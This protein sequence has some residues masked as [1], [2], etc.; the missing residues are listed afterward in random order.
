MVNIGGIELKGRFTLAPMAGVSDFAFRLICAELGAAM[1][2]TEMISAKAL[3]YRDE[4]TASLLYNPP[5]PCPLAVQIFGHEPEVMAEAA[6]MA[7]EGSGADI[8]DINMGCPVGKIVKSG[9]GSALMRDPE[10]AGRIIEAVCAA[11][12]Q[13]VTVKFRKGWDGGSVNAVAFA[14]VCEQAGASA[15]AVHGRTRVQMYAGKADWDIIR[16]V[17]KAVHIPVTANGD[18]FSGAD[19]AHILRYTGCDLAMIGR[20]SFGNPWLFMQAN[21]VL[22]GKPEPELPPLAERIDT[23]VAQIERLAEVSGERIACLEARHH[24][25]WYLHGVAYSGFYRQQLV[26]VE[27]LEDIHRLAKEMKRDLK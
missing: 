20:G 15:I 4:K 21:A 14:Q 6:P 24:L 1:V 23:A 25:P 18:I 3:V 19:A 5:M 7:L 10:L 2:T 8:L 12:N 17:K 11:V 16:Q 26:H 9:D 13:P 22:D 27:T